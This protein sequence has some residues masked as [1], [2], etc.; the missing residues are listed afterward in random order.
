VVFANGLALSP[1]GERLYVA[2]TFANRVFRISI[3]E[4]G[5]AGHREEVATLPGAW[6]DGLAFDELGY[7]YVGCYEPSQVLR[8]APDGTVDVLF[9]EWSAHLLAHPTNLA[10]RGTTL[11]TAN[12]GRW[13]ISR[14]E[15]G[16]G[17]LPLPPGGWR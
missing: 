12:L 17:G 1:K 5:T 6:P 14:L 10:F 9:R 4:D 13:H 3:R 7:L 16:V 15:V 11:F 2:E 8:I